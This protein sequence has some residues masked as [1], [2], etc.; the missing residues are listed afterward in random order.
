MEDARAEAEVVKAVMKG[1]VTKAEAKE[2]VMVKEEAMRKTVEE[3][4]RRQ[5]SRRQLHKSTR[6]E[7]HRQARDRSLPKRG[8]RFHLRS[9]K[10]PANRV[11][12]RWLYSRT[13]GT[14]SERPRLHTKGDPR[15]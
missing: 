12:R 2:G 6:R 14:L 15:K 13:G 3:V 4:G 1:A 9:V 5:R 8:T 10:K 7:Q 11:Q